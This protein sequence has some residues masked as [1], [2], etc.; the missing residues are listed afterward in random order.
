MNRHN[1][2]HNDIKPQNFLVK[3]C[4]G[5]LSFI[6]IV[7]TD[8]GLARSDAKGGTPFFASPECLANPDRKEADIFSLG[9][10]F[11]FS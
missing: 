5:D 2:I 3:F 6:E 10:L 1:Q 11:F 4:A 8:F 7:L 9:R